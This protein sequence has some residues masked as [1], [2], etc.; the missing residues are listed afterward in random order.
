MPVKGSTGLKRLLL[1]LI[2]LV[3]TACSQQPSLMEPTPAAPVLAVIEGMPQ[4]AQGDDRTEIVWL[5]PAEWSH[6]EH[7]VAEFEAQNSDIRV[8]IKQVSAETIFHEAENTLVVGSSSP[9]VVTLDASLSA[10]YGSNGWLESLYNDFTFDQKQDWIRSSR[11]SSIFN[12]EA[13]SGKHTKSSRS[14]ESCPTG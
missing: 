8:E 11:L 2:S 13:K 5:V 7:V 14:G 3:A 12:H 6:L 1:V 10:Y 9:D 4:R